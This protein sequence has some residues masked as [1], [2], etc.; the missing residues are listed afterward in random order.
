MAIT[1]PR[2]IK[3]ERL[4]PKGTWKDTLC[5]VHSFVDRPASIEENSGELNATMGLSTGVRTVRMQ[6]G[7]VHRTSPRP[8]NVRAGRGRGPGRCTFRQ[9]FPRAGRRT[10]A[11]WRVGS[12]PTQT[13]GHCYRTGRLASCHLLAV[14]IRS[15]LAKRT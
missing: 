5:P 9:V 6:P 10:V 15:V 12:I 14:R 1:T 7:G 4:L 13:V 2:H 3:A 11:A 8:R